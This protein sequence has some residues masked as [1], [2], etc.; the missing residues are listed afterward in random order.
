MTTTSYTANFLV[1]NS[2]YTFKIEA[3]TALGYSD[4]S[5]EISIRAAAKPDTPAVPVTTVVSNTDVVI[6]WTPPFN[7]G[8]VITSYTI[9]IR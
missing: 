7:G 4:Y 3:R 8:S 2:V 1:A 9:Q 6:A 5:S